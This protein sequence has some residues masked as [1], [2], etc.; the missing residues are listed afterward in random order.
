MGRPYLIVGRA[1][2]FLEPRLFR[3]CGF[4]EIASDSPINGGTP[5]DLFEVSSHYND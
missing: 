5:Y 1:D 3:R 4:P 2:L